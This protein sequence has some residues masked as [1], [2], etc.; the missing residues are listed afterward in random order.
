M[1][2]EIIEI[3]KIQKVSKSFQLK[4]T[5][6]N[7]YEMTKSDCFQNLPDPR[8]KYINLDRILKENSRFQSSEI[9]QVINK[10]KNKTEKFLKRRLCKFFAIL[11]NLSDLELLHPFLRELFSLLFK[12]L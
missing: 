3:Q 7:R 9:T 10:N 2:P 8:S 5:W 11:F 4:S 6:E 12:P 1:G